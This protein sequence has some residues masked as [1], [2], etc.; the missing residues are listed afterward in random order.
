[1]RLHHLPGR[2]LPSAAELGGD[3]LS[4]ARLLQRGRQGRALRG[5]GG[6]RAV[7]GG[8]P[9]RVQVTAEREGVMS[10]TVE[11]AVEVRPFHAEIAQEEVDDLRRRLAATRWPDKETVAD[12]S[13]GIE[14]A[15]LK[16]LVDYWATDYDWGRRAAK[17][18][19]LPRFIP[20]I[21]GLDIPF[22]HVRSS[23]DDALPLIVT[24]GWPGSVFELLK[25]V[26][27]LTEP[28]SGEHAFHVVIPSL[29]GFGF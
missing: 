13:Q 21:D 29:P 11:T 22:I 20:E 27:P 26:E 3:A 2:D 7:L 4:D 16:G 1:G 15:K 9:R 12:A 18:N 19:A 25:I 14:L 6:A 23:H 10:S 8:A 28:P 5:L 17:L 24:H